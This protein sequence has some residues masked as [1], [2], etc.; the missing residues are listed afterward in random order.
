ME[1]VRIADV[2]L[3]QIVAIQ[4]KHLIEISSTCMMYLLVD[5]LM[6]P[7][8]EVQATTTSKYLM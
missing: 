6:R 5:C 3:G 1:S 8:V 7:P 4:T 2:F